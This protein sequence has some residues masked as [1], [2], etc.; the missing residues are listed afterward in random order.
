MIFVSMIVP[1]LILCAAVSYAVLI[2]RFFLIK[3]KLPV[4]GL[5]GTL[6]RTK[7][8]RRKQAARKEKHTT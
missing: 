3:S 5:R 1:V 8:K 6:G 2:R 4:M 7:G